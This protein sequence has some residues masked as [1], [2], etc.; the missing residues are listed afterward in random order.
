MVL[1]CLNDILMSDLPQ[2]NSMEVRSL[3]NV[4]SRLDE[5]DT[6]RSILSRLGGKFRNYISILNVESDQAAE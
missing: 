3:T 1:R 2:T 4:L 5:F 6:L